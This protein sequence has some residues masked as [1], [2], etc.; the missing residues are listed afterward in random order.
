MFYYL[1]KD[2]NIMNKELF[3]DSDNSI[4]NMPNKFSIMNYSNLRNV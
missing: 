3:Y 4:K 1:V 2:H